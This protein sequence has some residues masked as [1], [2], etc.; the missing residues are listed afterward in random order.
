MPA[1]DETIDDMS[2]QLQRAH[3]IQQL[4]M[5]EAFADCGVEVSFVSPKTTGK[6]PSWDVVSEF[7]GLSSEFE[8]RGVPAPSKNYTFPNYPIPDTEAQAVTSWLI[9]SYLTGRFDEGDVIFSRNLRPTRQFL[10]FLDLIGGGDSISIWF[11][12]HMVDR[13][14]DDLPLDI[15]FYGQLDGIVCLSAR[16]KQRMIETHSIPP[17]KLLTAHDGVN[18]GAYTEISKRDARRQ[19]GYDP[20]E[21]IVMYTGHLY[22]G[23]DVETMVQ[24]ASDID[25]KCVVVGGYDTDI[26]RIKSECA[27]PENVVFEGFVSPGEIPTYQTAADVLVATMAADPGEDYFSPL[28]LFEYMAAG[29]PMVVSRKLDFEEVLSHGQ[30]T[31]FVEPGS[32]TDLADALTQLLSDPDL[33]ER[34]AEQARADVHRYDWRARAERLLSA[35][36]AFDSEPSTDAHFQRSVGTD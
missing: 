24:A 10:A 31:L 17:E 8:L 6:T 3:A 15:D 18:V 33:R 5:C 25:A 35:F 27:V 7:Y 26:S 28:K 16:Q 4:R 29:N 21:Q 9:Y 34:L 2:D 1:A 11:A 22:P 23:K 32:A 14:L 30:N 20:D 12:Q 13:G 19:L 36:S